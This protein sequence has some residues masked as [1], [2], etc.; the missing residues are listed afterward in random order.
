LF[1]KDASDDATKKLE[2]NINELVLRKVKKGVP[3]DDIN[4]KH[5]FWDTQPVPK[6]SNYYKNHR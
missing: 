4:K 6:L 1:Q 2:E 5:V 3:V